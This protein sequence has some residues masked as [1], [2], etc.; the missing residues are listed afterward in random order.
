MSTGV[1]MTTDETQIKAITE[2]IK[3]MVRELAGNN[4]NL[5]LSCQSVLV[6]IIAEETNSEEVNPITFFDE[7][8]RKEFKEKIKAKLAGLSQSQRLELLNRLI[9]WIPIFLK[10]QSKPGAKKS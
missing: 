9:F 10:L 4:K 7:T 1:V 8:S 3:V 2:E 6:E 5:T